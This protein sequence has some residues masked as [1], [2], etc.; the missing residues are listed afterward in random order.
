MADIEVKRT[1][2]M[3]KDEARKA[4]EEIAQSL[5]EKLDVRYHWD[6]DHLRFSRKGAEGFLRVGDDD[7]EIQI[8]LGLMFKPLRGTIERRI[9]EYLD[10]EV[11]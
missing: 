1:H 9:V 7:L 3:A 11:S 5:Q 6:G 8:K 2:S 10:R 4:A